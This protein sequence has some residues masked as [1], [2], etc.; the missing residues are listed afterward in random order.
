VSD[1]IQPQPKIH[2]ESF[3]HPS[4]ELWGAVEI[5]EY[6]LVAP[7][8]SI[9]ADEGT[10]FKI[11][12]GTNIQD[13][14][15]MHGLYGKFVTV[16]SLD[17]SIYV[18]SHCSI[19]HGAL[20][21][22]PSR[23]DKKTFIGFKAIVHSAKIGRNCYVGHG[24][25]VLGVELPDNTYVPNGWIIDRQEQIEELKRLTMPDEAKEFN[26]EVVDRNKELVKRHK[27]QIMP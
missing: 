26:K 19:A 16:D 27:S 3:V 2:K 20:V 9:R 4:A 10:P 18:G 15:I 1:L 25:Q 21:H 7:H 24:A 17:Y 22:G 14:V 23:I 13:G 12:Q 6:V 5:E 8:V 11:C